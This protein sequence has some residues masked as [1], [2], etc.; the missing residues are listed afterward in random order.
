MLNM[1][2]SCNGDHL[3]DNELP[4]CI[5]LIYTNLTVVTGSQTR[6]GSST[7]SLTEIME[8]TIQIGSLSFPNTGT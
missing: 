2:V 6:L 7:N 5:N 3:C 8:L 4:A 1:V